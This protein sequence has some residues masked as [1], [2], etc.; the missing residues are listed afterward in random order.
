M[1]GGGGVITIDKARNYVDRVVEDLGK[2]GYS[3]QD[4]TLLDELPRFMQS[5]GDFRF[6]NRSYNVCDFRK[7]LFAQSFPGMKCSHSLSSLDLFKEA[8]SLAVSRSEK[9]NLSKMQLDALQINGFEVR[10]RMP[11]FDSGG[12]SEVR[13]KSEKLVIKIK[14]RTDGTSCNIGLDVFQ[15][16]KLARFDKSSARRLG[17]RIGELTPD[18]GEGDQRELYSTLYRSANILRAGHKVFSEKKR[19]P[20]AAFSGEAGILKYINDL[21]REAAC[22]KRNK[23]HIWSSLSSV[24]CLESK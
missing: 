1:I 24:T 8:R 2:D 15:D 22:G 18:R 20:W 14:D 21:R 17:E 4:L 23:Q 5:R 16:G 3:E 13:L 19:L 12:C 11:P 10:E 6:E 7:G 9:I